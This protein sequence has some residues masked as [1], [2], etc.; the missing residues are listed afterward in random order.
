MKKLLLTVIVATMLFACKK[1]NDAVMPNNSIV[2]AQDTKL[3]GS[4]S[5][6]STQYDG[7]DVIYNSG[8]KSLS[9]LMVDSV[10]TA[11]SGAYPKSNWK[12]KGDTLYL[13]LET[14]V[15][16]K[17][18]IPYHYEL[19]DNKLKTYSNNKAIVKQQTCWYHKL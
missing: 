6:D 8:G 18:F 4:W 12:T 3:L 16:I 19:N 7:A 1:S 11:S 2:Y 15:A 17:N 9:T 10:F 14:P 13:S 5:K